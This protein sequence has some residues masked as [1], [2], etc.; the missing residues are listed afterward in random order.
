MEAA[1][2]GNESIIRIQA[3][4]LDFQRFLIQTTVPIFLAG[5][6]FG[7]GHRTSVTFLG[8]FKGLVKYAKKIK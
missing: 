7:I 8:L 6:M 5:I 4:G 1:G 2:I 3:K